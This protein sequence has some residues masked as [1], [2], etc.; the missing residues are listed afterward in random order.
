MIILSTPQRMEP[1]RSARLSGVDAFLRNEA[2]ER[3]ARD[4]ARRA[5]PDYAI[6]KLKPI[7]VRKSA[8]TVPRLVVPPT[9]TDDEMDLVVENTGTFRRIVPSP[10]RAAPAAVAVV[11]LPA[12][13]GRRGRAVGKP[14]SYY[15]KLDRA[16]A[17][18]A[19]TKAAYLALLPNMGMKIGDFGKTAKR[20]LVKP[21]PIGAAKWLAYPTEYDFPGIDDGYT[22]TSRTGKQYRRA[23][24]L[25]QAMDD[26]IT[27]AM[28]LAGSGKYAAGYEKNPRRV[29]A[30]RAL[31]ARRWGR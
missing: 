22:Y 17:K 23:R 6:R 1:R 5:R 31:A 9:P 12:A 18:R 20:R 13:R 28:T 4:K 29:A 3:V 26:R 15:D 10:G 19:A 14:Q 25:G 24:P 8:P 27:Y 7:P 21:T 2:R 30:G 11:P 16:R